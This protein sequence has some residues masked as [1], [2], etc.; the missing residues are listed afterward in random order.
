MDP[1]VAGLV[2]G[3]FRIQREVGRGGAGIVYRATDSLSRVEVALK[4]IGAHHVAVLEQAGFT[5]GGQILS[6]LDHPGIVRVV[7]FGAIDGSSTDAYGR[8][9][10][11]GSP[12]IAMEWLEGE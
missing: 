9:F 7:A 5:R 12:Y 4:G 11:E 3:R 2:A 10:E 8:R 6:A 1:L